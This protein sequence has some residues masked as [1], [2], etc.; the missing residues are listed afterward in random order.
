VRYVLE[1]ILNCPLSS[2][3]IVCIAADGAGEYERGAYYSKKAHLIA[4]D[5]KWAGLDSEWWRMSS[6]NYIIIQGKIERSSHYSDIKMKSLTKR[7]FIDAFSNKSGDIAIQFEGIS[8]RLTTPWHDI[9]HASQS[10]MLFGDP[11]SQGRL[12]TSLIWKTKP[13]H[14]HHILC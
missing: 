5:L 1:N 8:T 13:Q 9:I 12:F 7:Q 6:K 10:I 3:L 14:L 4:S 11:V 2:H